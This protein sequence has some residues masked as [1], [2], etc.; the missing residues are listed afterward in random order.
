MET[1]L[2]F[3]GKNLFRL[4]TISQIQKHTNGITY[5]SADCKGSW[6]RCTIII[7]IDN[8]VG[9]GLKELVHTWHIP[10]TIATVV[11]IMTQHPVPTYIVCSG[12]SL[13]FVL[14]V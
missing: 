5:V 14:C 3:S 9:F 6:V 4:L 13:Q 10:P 11:G 12:I 7:E 2:F 1:R 8:V